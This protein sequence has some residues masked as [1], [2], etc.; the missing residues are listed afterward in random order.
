[1][2][3]VNPVLPA[4]ESKA[5]LFSLIGSGIVWGGIWVPLKYFAAF[6]LTGHVI[7]LTA[8]AMVA[9]ATLPLVWRER[10]LWRPELGLLILIGLFFGF[11]NM[12]FTTALMTGSVVRAMLLFYLLPAWGAIG[13]AIFLR[14]RIGPRRLLAILLS[15]G[16]VFIIMGG[17][18]VLR[19]PLSVADLCALSAGLFY[20]AA[21]IVNRKARVIPL[22]SRTLVSFIGCALVAVCWLALSVPV[23]PDLSMQTWGLLALFAFVWL[24]GGTMLTTF[25]VTHIQAS[26]AAVL[27]VVELLVAVLSAVWLGG[28][29]LSL[30]DCLGAVLIVMATLIEATSQ[31]Q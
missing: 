7:G 17:V 11:A 22:T 14:E 29:Q 30:T 10:H 5:A 2:T 26:R 23:I 13:G 1:M 18:D 31:P 28:E 16:G 15:L 8:Y 21:A 3:A 20:T 4:K 19:E 12:V 25:G 24:L 9:L 6:G 27:M